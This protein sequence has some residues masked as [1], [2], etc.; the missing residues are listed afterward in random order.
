MI[1][2][3]VNKY[4]PTAGKLLISEPFLF[5][6]NFKR[7][8]V[9]LVENSSE[10]TVGFILN[11]SLDF[12]LGEVIDLNVEKNIQ[13]HLGGPVDHNTLHYIHCDE[14]LASESEKIGENLYWGGSFDKVFEKINNNTLELEKYKFFL[15][16]S[17]WTPGQ[18][19][20]EM[21]TN[22]WIVADVSAEMIFEMDEE[23]MWQQILKNMGGQF[24]LMAEYPES[25]QLN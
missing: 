6:N 2:N 16:Y 20:L 7:S 13:L 12:G 17:G 24:K 22:S 19:D 3:F 11:K 8:V 14:E 9:L 1:G 15:G 18:L 4:E 10:S 5:D 21:S 25:P 23:N